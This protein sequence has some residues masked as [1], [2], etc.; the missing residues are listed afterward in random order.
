MGVGPKPIPRNKL[1]VKR[2]SSAILQVMTDQKLRNNALILGKRLSVEDGV[3]NAIGIIE[4][5]SRHHY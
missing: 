1:N 4:H 3:G 5:L 2:L